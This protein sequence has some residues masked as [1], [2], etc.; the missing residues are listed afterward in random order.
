MR[1]IS[2]L[3]GYIS[4]IY[5]PSLHKKV[6]NQIT[7][8]Y[9]KWLSREFKNFGK[10]VIIEPS[11]I[12]GGANT[13]SLG[14]GV[15]IGKRTVLA[16]HSTYNGIKY[17]PSIEIGNNV[18][19]GQDSNISCINNIKIANNV[20]IGRKVM[21]NDNSHGVFERNM[22]DIPPRL[23]PLSSKGSITIDENVWIGEMV[24]ILSGVHIGRGSIIGAGSI[25]TKDVPPYSLAAGIPAKIIKQLN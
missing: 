16:A 9:T 20:L 14:N 25:V 23:R 12:L 15:R 19:I 3:L 2:Q 4:Y 13:I 22:L 21:I 17:N 5:P 1:I 11:I 10:N 6:S 7:L 8:L 18:N 24:C